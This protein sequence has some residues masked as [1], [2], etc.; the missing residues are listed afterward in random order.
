MEFGSFDS[1]TSVFSIVLFDARKPK[2][3][4]AH[5]SFSDTP[6][7]PEVNVDG[8]LW[9]TNEDL[10]GLTSL[11]TLFLSFFVIV[12]DFTPDTLIQ[13]LLG[14]TFLSCSLVEN[15]VVELPSEEKY[16]GGKEYLSNLFQSSYSA[17]QMLVCLTDM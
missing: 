1:E 17:V 4:A 12:N 16:N 7:D 15:V 6:Q 9:K 13:E 14:Y 10:K 8:K 2:N 5:A 3:L 11:N